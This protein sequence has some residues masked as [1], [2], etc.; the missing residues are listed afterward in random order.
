ML[1][2]DLYHCYADMAIYTASEALDALAYTYTSWISGNNYR[3]KYSD[4]KQCAL[5]F[6]HFLENEFDM[7]I[8]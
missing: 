6:I 1:K 7:T 5:A 8:N 4:F 3:Y 2:R